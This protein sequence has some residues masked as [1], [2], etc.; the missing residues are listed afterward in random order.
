[1]LV[2]GFVKV[3]GV[4]PSIM[5]DNALAHINASIG[6]G[7]NES[8]M[9]RF[10]QQSF[11]PELRNQ[12]PITDLYQKTPVLELVESLLGEGVTLPVNS[13]QIAVRFPVIQD[14]LCISSRSRQGLACAHEG[15]LAP[16][17]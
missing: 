7:M 2:N 1:M 17:A 10:R 6:R 4:I 15:C 3:P 13:G 11:C 8:D 14:T 9:Q 16:L 5:V 12:S